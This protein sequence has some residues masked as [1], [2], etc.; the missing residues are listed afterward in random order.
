[1]PLEE[2]PEDAGEE[3]SELELDGETD[4]DGERDERSDEIVADAGLPPDVPADKPD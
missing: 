2:E 1:L 3:Q 4:S